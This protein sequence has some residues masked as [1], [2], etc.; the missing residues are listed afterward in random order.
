MFFYNGFSL[1]DSV[2]KSLLFSFSQ[3]YSEILIGF[4]STLI[5]AR[6]LTPEEVG[7]YS[8]IATLTVIAH[9]VRDFGVS[10][11]I[12]QERALTDEK[13][14]SAFLVTFFWS[15]S[16]GLT[17]LGFSTFISD[18]FNRPE[19]IS[20]VLVSSLGFAFIPFG[21]VSLNLL[22]KDM[23]FKKLFFINVSS[24]IVS[25]MFSISLAY[26]GFSYMSLAWGSLSGIVT[27]VI[28]S[29][30]FRRKV[31]LETPRFSVISEVFSFG[32]KS[33]YVAIIS[34]LVTQLPE[35]LIAK[36]Y[37]MTSVGLYSRANGL[38]NMFNMGFLQGVFPVLLPHLVNK[39]KAGGD[40]RK[41]FLTTI[42]VIATLA[43]PFF[44]FLSFF[45]TEII[46]FL[47]GDQ[48]VGA[49]AILSYL[50]IAAAA[51]SIYSFNSQVLISKGL[52]NLDVKTQTV[53]QASSAILL[54]AFSFYGL[55]YILIALI[56]SRFFTLFL[57]FFYCL[58]ALDVKFYVFLSS[59]IKPALVT[60]LCTVYLTVFEASFD[61]SLAEFSYLIVGSTAYTLIWLLSIAMCRSTLFSI[62]RELVRFRRS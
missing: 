53:S 13:I 51:A 59:L 23:Q 29:S 57:S 37:G 27:I 32:S 35:I 55:D 54:I 58:R 40:I 42:E 46:G 43:W 31:K 21:S 49:S 6:L 26:V 50:C 38:I 15:Y 36:L 45:S 28:L 9:M 5:L 20:V 44:L 60:I 33:S 47:F 19:L 7:I 62:I 8:V 30:F 14:I 24:V 61:E 16:I 11:Y 39:L 52:I 48:W 1:M 25:S 18:F 17:F 3:K 41:D 2:K 56:I 34:K 4:I 12:V 10:N 22:R